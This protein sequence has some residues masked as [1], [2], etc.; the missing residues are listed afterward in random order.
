MLCKKLF[1]I[2]FS[3]VVGL[4]VTL[5]ILVSY[6]GSQLVEDDYGRA[7]KLNLDVDAVSKAFET[8]KSP[9]EFEKKVNEIYTG[10]EIISISVNNTGKNKQSVVLYIDNNPQNAKTDNGERLLSFNRDFDTESNKS[11]YTRTGYG[12]YSH[13]L[14]IY[15][16]ATGALTYWTLPRTLYRTPIS[17]YSTI[18]RS[19]TSYRSTPA[20]RKQVTR[21]NSFNKPF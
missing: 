6:S 9:Q 1:K 20:Y 2:V 11:S 19:R 3:L 10:Y 15:Y 7:S 8:A 17:S 4:L 13:H 18:K 16:A 12:S 21:A 5:Y 14:P